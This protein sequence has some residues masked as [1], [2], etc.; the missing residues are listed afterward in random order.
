MIGIA[1]LLYFAGG[2]VFAL[3]VRETFVSRDEWWESLALMILVGTPMAIA[4][5]CVRLWQEAVCL[6]KRWQR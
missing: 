6:V 1:A 3:V 5:A 4:L 2:L